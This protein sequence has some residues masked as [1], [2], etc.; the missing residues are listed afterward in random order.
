MWPQGALTQARDGNFYGTTAVGGRWAAGTVFKISPEGE[1][2][3]IAHFDGTN[4]YWPYGALLEASDGNFYG[5][6]LYGW[7]RGTFFRVTPGGALTNF[8]TWQPI[9]PL[10]DFAQGPDGKLYG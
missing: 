9:H 8:G 2:T 10:G 5:S 7:G 4:G 3:T 1:F 6:T